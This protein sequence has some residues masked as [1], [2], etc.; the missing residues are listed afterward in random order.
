M[1]HTVIW[2]KVAI[3]SD[4]Q[5][6]RGDNVADLSSTHFL[7]FFFSDSHIVY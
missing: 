3:F 5:L 6:H 7:F 1:E 2:K 4:A